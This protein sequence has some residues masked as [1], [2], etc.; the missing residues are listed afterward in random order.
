[1][2]VWD[3]DTNRQLDPPHWLFTGHMLLW[4]DGSPAHVDMHPFQPADGGWQADLMI[5]R[6]TMSG[7]R[8]LTMRMR[9]SPEVR[10]QW[11]SEGKSA[12]ARALQVLA[13]YLRITEWYEN[14][15]GVLDL[16]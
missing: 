16:K 8:W 13:N 3:D 4:G 6:S 1:M 11:E 9:I 14:D 5:S 10:K 2:A 12:R 7:T 15:M